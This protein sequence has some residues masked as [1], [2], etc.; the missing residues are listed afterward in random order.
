MGEEEPIN[1]RLIPLKKSNCLGLD[2]LDASRAQ[3]LPACVVFFL[4]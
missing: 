4:A 2:K 3:Q 1:E